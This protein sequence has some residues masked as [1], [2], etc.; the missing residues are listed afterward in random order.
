MNASWAL[1]SPVATATAVS[2]SCS[3]LTSSGSAGPAPNDGLAVADR[4]VIRDVAL[5]ARRSPPGSR[6]CDGTR[7]PSRIWS[8]AATSAVSAL[9]QSRLRYRI[10]LR[11]LP[12][13]GAHA[14]AASPTGAT[15]DAAVEEWVFAAWTPDASLGVISGHRIVG[16]TAWYWAALARAGS[17]AAAHHRLRRAGACRSRSS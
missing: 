2:Q 14:D 7:R 8:L 12:D 13:R 3:I 4:Q 9:I 15:P 10:M 16:R 1:S 6:R 17:P 11:S 5:R